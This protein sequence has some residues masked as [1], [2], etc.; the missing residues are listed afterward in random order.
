MKMFKKIGASVCAL[1]LSAGIAV[2]AFAASGSASLPG[3]DGGDALTQPTD[4]PVRVIAD[5]ADAGTKYRVDLEWD[6]LDFTYDFGSRSWNVKTHLIDE[7]VGGDGWNGASSSI[8]LTNHSNIGIGYEASFLPGQTSSGDA[9]LIL[10]GDSGS[11]DNAYTEHYGKFNEADQGTITAT[12]GGTPD[13]RMAEGDSVQIG[14]VK[15]VLT[16]AGE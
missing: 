9:R 3:E 7:G 5:G 16:P 13:T 12:P 6:D 8:T 4:I 1:A 2:P 10:T 15:I 11:L 14:T